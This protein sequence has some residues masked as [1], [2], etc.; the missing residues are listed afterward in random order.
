MKDLELMHYFL[1]MEVW[2]GDEEFLSLRESM[3]MR[4]SKGSTWREV[5]P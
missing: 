1:G 3:V 4:Y 2:Q 5:N